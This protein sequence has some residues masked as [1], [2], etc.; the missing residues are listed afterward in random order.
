MNDDRDWTPPHGIA[1][2]GVNLT[3]PWRLTAVIA[4]IWLVVGSIVWLALR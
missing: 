4:V 3:H 1:R 2:P